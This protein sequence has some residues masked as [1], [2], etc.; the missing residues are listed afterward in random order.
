MI[1]EIAAPEPREGNRLAAAIQAA[2]GQPA[3]V[4]LVGDR[5]HIV[6]EATEAE[7]QAAVAA[8][9]GTPDPVVDPDEEL[10]TAISEASTL[11]ELKAA[12]LGTA[13]EAQA[14][15]AGR[16]TSE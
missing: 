6:T 9:D 10:R 8:H 16:P 7:V 14:R 1:H 3:D 12:L 11:P 4:M 2:T 13:P 15:V 5:W